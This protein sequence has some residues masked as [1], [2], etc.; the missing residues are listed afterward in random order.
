MSPLLT[1]LESDSWLLVLPDNP[2]PG[3]CTRTVLF[4]SVLATSLPCVAWSSLLTRAELEA[5]DVKWLSQSLSVGAR[6]GSQASTLMPL[7]VS[8]KPGFL[9]SAAADESVYLV[10]GAQPACA[11]SNSHPESPLPAPVL[12]CHSP[13]PSVQ[14]ASPSLSP[15]RLGHINRNSETEASSLSWLRAGRKQPQKP[16][17][18]RT[19]HSTSGRGSRPLSEASDGVSAL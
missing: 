9:L 14:P 2:V 13:T 4:R 16:V 11:S 3:V 19:G 15:V 6:R 7:S 5:Q 10:L 17:S 1:G 12:T 18:E 8:L